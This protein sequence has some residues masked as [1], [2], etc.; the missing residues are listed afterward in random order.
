MQLTY[1][2]SVNRWE[3]DEND[4]LNVRFCEQ[5]LWQTLATGVHMTTGLGADGNAGLITR[6]TR[7]H[8]RFQR[9]ARLSVPLSGYFAWL[10]DASVPDF[11][12]VTEL[13][14]SDTG[15]V[16]FSA[17]HHIRQ[18]ASGLASIEAAAIDPQ[19]LPRGITSDLLAADITMGQAQ[20]AGFKLIGRGFIQADEC[21]AT[22]TLLKHL[23]M[24]RISD[25]MPHLWRGLLDD[26][27]LLADG[28]EEG[29]AVLEF[30]KNYH[31]ELRADDSYSLLSGVVGVAPKVQQFAH[32]LFNTQTEQLIVS[33]QAVAVRLDLIA[34]KAATLSDAMVAQLQTKLVRLPG[35]AVFPN[36]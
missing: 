15:E 7:Q 28:A 32:L 30:R 25:S 34:R 4:H 6:V 27:G 21:A 11:N 35:S 2:G 13:R 10:D 8:L 14:H 5:K 22:G 23:Y 24:G 26:A 18:D 29:G 31:G 1:R 16:M 33:A 20:Q 3:C 36:T 9:E 17:L 19:V 12:A